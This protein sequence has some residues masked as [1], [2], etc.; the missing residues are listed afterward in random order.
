MYCPVY[1]CNSDSKNNLNKELHFFPFPGLSRSEIRNRRKIWIH[2]DDDAYNPAYSP[3]FLKSIGCE[4]QTLVLLRKDAVPT[5][6]KPLMETAETKQSK[7]TEERLRRKVIINL[8]II[9][10]F[11]VIKAHGLQKRLIKSN[12][13]IF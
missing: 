6:N 2:F 8:D 3:K 12:F 4:D 7:T 13:A 1:G 10:L 11:H 5:L 9:C